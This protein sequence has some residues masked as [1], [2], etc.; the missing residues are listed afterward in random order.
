MAGRRAP[1][2]RLTTRAGDL[3][4]LHPVKVA[5]AAIVGMTTVLGVL[6]AW[7]AVEEHF[8]LR[9]EGEAHQAKV[10][11]DM[12]AVAKRLEVSRL[13]SEYGRHAQDRRRL[14]KAVRDS[15]YK[16][17]LSGTLMPAEQLTLQA[18]HAD[19][20]AAAAAMAEVKRAINALKGAP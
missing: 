1:T 17:Q 5:L 9:R 6:P 11:A 19:L 3:F 2:A 7:W 20:D 13:W 8:W 14:E 15:A 10:Q 18:D 12:D 16:Q 4:R